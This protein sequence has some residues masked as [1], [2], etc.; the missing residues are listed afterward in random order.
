MLFCKV[1][2]VAVFFKGVPNKSSQG[3]GGGWV[4]VDDSMKNGKDLKAYLHLSN[5]IHRETQS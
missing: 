3:E 4:G 2:K 1:C 5:D